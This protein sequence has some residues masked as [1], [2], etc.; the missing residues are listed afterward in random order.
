MVKSEISLFSK[1]M[2][3]LFRQEFGL[4][5]ALTLDNLHPD[6]EDRANAPIL[7]IRLPDESEHPH[8]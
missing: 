1:R 4:C 8:N 7:C 6:E 5:C 2:D 3:D